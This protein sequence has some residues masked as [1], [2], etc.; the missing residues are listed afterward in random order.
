MQEWR[1]A[2]QWWERIKNWRIKYIEM[3]IFVLLCH[4]NHWIKSLEK[5]KNVYSFLKCN[6]WFKCLQIVIKY[7]I[8]FP[9]NNFLGNCTSKIIKHF[10]T[11][12]RVKILINRYK[13]IKIRLPM[14]KHVFLVP[15]Y[16]LGNFISIDR[17]LV[18][19]WLKLSGRVYR[20]KFNR[21]SFIKFNLLQ[22]RK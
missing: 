3:D 22:L 2:I 1:N 11:S 5:Q 7:E 21:L 6:L 12:R 18:T 9:W 8:G 17:I 4:S 13:Q 14:T 16:R 19:Y 15:G 10:Y 20:W